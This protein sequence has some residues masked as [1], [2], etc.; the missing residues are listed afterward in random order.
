MYPHIKGGE[1]EYSLRFLRSPL[2]YG[3]QYLTQISEQGNLFSNIPWGLYPRDAYDLGNNYNF[4]LKNGARLYLDSGFHTEYATPEALLTRSLVAYEKTGEWLIEYLAEKTSKALIMDGTIRA[5]KDNIDRSGRTYGAHDNYYIFRNERTIPDALAH[6]LAPL[7]VAGQIYTG[8]GAVQ[9]NP[10]KPGTLAFRLSQRAPFL[11]NLV[12]GA[13]T[14]SRA[15]INTRDEVHGDSELY[16]R[17]HII[18]NDAGI[19]ETSLFLKYGITDIVL[20]MIEEAFLPLKPFGEVNEGELIKTLGE[21]SND[22]TLRCSAKF[23][24]RIDTAVGILEWF[25]ERAQKF[26]PERDRDAHPEWRLV[27]KLWEDFLMRAKTTRPHE[28]L[29]RTIN[30][31]AEY[32]LIEKDMERTGYDWNAKYRSNITGASGTDEEKLKKDGYRAEAIDVLFH[33]LSPRGFARKLIVGNE[34]DRILTDTEME[35]VRFRP[36][37]RETRAYARS[38]ELDFCEKEGR[39]RKKILDVRADWIYVKLMEESL[40]PTIRFYLQKDPFDWRI[41]PNQA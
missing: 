27:M 41:P 35:A 28:A 18:A 23:G 15:I 9:N 38:K 17:L 8:A 24:E 33:E 11:V 34:A 13:T 6:S 32:C 39:R 25:F 16:R 36:V 1:N 5:Y 37:P 20:D 4:W 10:R 26:G 3:T 22:P 12:G 14:S 2:G 29:R 30:W 7:I 19:L 21:I 31:A 40:G